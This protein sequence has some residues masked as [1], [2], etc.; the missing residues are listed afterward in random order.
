MV[1]A[2]I[3][4]VSVAGKRI[5][6]QVTSDKKTGEMTNGQV[7]DASLTTVKLASQRSFRA[8]MYAALGTSCTRVHRRC[9]SACYK[10]WCTGYNTFY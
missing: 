9:A 7:I 5:M 1:K 4:D 8:R 10:G 2:I 3:A 6:I